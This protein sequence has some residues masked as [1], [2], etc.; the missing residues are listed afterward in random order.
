MV[1]LQDGGAPGWWLRGLHGLGGCAGDG[2]QD[3]RNRARP[4][5]FGDG[6]RDVLYLVEDPRLVRSRAKCP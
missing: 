6:G 5:G 2:P 1:G 3:L 4:W